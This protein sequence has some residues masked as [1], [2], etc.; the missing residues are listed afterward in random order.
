MNTV[1]LDLYENKIDYC[2]NKALLF[3]QFS[4][5][6]YKKKREIESKIT[7]LGMNGKFFFGSGVLSDTQ[8]FVAYHKEKNFIV[9][10]FRGT[11]GNSIKDWVT[12]A[13]C[14]R[15]DHQLGDVH[16]G[17]NLAYKKVSDAIIS[18]VDHLK[19]SDILDNKNLIKIDEKPSIDVYICGHSLGGALATLCAADFIASS[20]PIAGVFTYG[21]PRVGDRS[22]AQIYNYDL[23]DRTYRFVNHKDV[24]TRVGPRIMG[25]YHVGS[26]KYITSSG[27][28]K[29]EVSWW[30]RFLDRFQVNFGD[31]ISENFDDHSLNE[32][33]TQIEKNC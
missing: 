32:D 10:S 15:T 3:A 1:N 27:D 12:D 33:L 22:F 29:S 25:F 11:E 14:A 28:I 2:H 5:L 18:Y 26:L 7:E 23:K 19:Y 21:S 24:V 16:Y 4:N 8:A 20:K 13:M 31:L 6:A 30:N 17:F 9:I